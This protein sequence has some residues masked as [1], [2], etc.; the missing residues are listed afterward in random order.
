MGGR[1]ELA[2][3]VNERLAPNPARPGYDPLELLDPAAASLPRAYLF[4]SR[5]PAMFPPTVS[6]AALEAAGVPITVVEGAHDLPLLDPYGCA[7]A[8]LVAVGSSS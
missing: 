7:Q 5:T 2:A 6:R 4:C 1:D 8:L 3:W